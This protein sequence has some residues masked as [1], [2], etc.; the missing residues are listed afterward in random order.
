[1]PKE[2]NPIKSKNKSVTLKKRFS[3]KENFYKENF[4]IVKNS[5]N[6][7]IRSNNLNLQNSI[8]PC[9][10]YKI[11]D[12]FQDN[13]SNV[14]SDKDSIYNEENHDLLENPLSRFTEHYNKFNENYNKFFS[15]K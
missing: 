7:E 15:E 3:T 12:E 13:L 8:T 5:K 2:Q 9:F 6:S 4:K 11:D 1:M 14:T 10:P